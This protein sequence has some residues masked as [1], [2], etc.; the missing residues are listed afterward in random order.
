[1]AL[2]LT[3]DIGVFNKSGLQD[4][5]GIFDNE[6]KLT[7]DPRID[8]V[9]S[10]REV[11]DAKKEADKRTF[12]IDRINQVTGY[13]YTT[14]KNI[15]NNLLQLLKAPADVGK[16]LIQIVTDP[17]GTAQS[18][19]EQSRRPFDPLLNYMSRYSKD[20]I[21]D[22]LTK[23]P[24]GVMLDASMVGGLGTI[25]VKAGSK[26]ISKAIPITTPEE[27]VSKAENITQRILNPSKDVIADSLLKNSKIP[28]VREAAKVI[29]KSPN[30]KALLVNLDD[31]IKTNFT[32]RN[33]ILESNNYRMTDNH[34][35]NLE[36]FI[37]E[38]KL[39]G[40]VNPSELRQMENVLA[41]EKAWYV[42]NKD[43]FNRV[44]GQKRKEYLQ[45]ITESLIEK[46]ADG[47]KAITQPARKQA[48]D[49]LRSGLMKEVEGN[50]LR[51]RDLNSTYSG[52]LDAKEML[53]NQAAIVEQNASKGTMERLVLLVQSAANPQAAAINIA[54][55]NAKNISRT[56]SQI[57]KLMANATK[58]RVKNVIDA[59]IKNEEIL[60]LPNLT[61][62]YLRDRQ[63]M[64]IDS[65]GT[66]TKAAIDRPFQIKGV[67]DIGTIE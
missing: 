32:E 38:R 66:K 65:L 3:D 11:S 19:A 9:D 34:I 31:A 41:E 8:M 42:K 35:K 20:N 43:S 54:L 24:I 14:P 22:T 64:K 4:D 45:N 59:A 15:G 37:N 21:K 18:I 36:T 10:N 52:L 56:S 13:P 48:L 51:V 39:A 46:R 26:A 47:T 61:P 27:M 49:V 33:L 30:E 58:N 5:L 23:D 53:A 60:G 2:D 63:E 1:M 29:R 7:G 28:A 17:K 12:S 62:R 44:G 67:G 6:P 40:Q 25:G 50:D 16:T 57:E 55:K